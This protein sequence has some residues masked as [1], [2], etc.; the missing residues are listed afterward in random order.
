MQELKPIPY[1]MWDGPSAKRDGVSAR[2]IDMVEVDDDVTPKEI[3][4]FFWASSDSKSAMKPPA[5]T[6]LHVNFEIGRA[7]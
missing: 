4:E 3:E 6:V 1:D 7:W 2:A 5:V